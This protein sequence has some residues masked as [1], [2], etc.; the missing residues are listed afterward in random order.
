[1]LRRQNCLDSVGVILPKTQIEKLEVLFVVVVVV[2]L[3]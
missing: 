2:L 1:M 3:D